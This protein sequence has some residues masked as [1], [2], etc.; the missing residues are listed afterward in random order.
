MI[1]FVPVG[2]D[3]SQNSVVNNR[4]NLGYHAM[5]KNSYWYVQKF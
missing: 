5:N 4:C 2:Q 3:F 1:E